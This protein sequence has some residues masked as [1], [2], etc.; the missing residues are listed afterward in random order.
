MLRAESPPAAVP[1]FRL[2][3]GRFGVL[4][5]VLLALGKAVAAD[6]SAE[7]Q[8]WLELT[9]RFRADPQAELEKLVNFSSPGVWG[10]PKSDDPSIAYAL[11]YFGT[12]A[13]DLATQFSSLVAAPPVAW[14][15]L[16]NVSATDYSNLMVTS[17][18]QSH[19]LDGYT[20]DQ[21][22]E[23][24]GYSANWLELG[25]NLF[26]STESIIHGHAGFVIDWG[27]GNGATAG[28]GNGIQNPAGHR[29]VLINPFMKEIGIGFQD[30]AIP[31]SNVSAVGPYVVTQH[32]ATEFRF[33][34]STYFSDAILTGSVYQDTIAADLFYTPGEG[35]A[36]EVI[37]VYDDATGILVAS[38]FSNSA[39]G[40]NIPLTGLTD[41]VVYRVEAPDTGL[42][43]QTF[44]LNAHTEDYG[45]PVIFYD[46]V[47]SSFMMVPEPGSLLLCLLAAV[48][49]LGFR[50]RR[51]F[52]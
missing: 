7:Q 46:N 45:A 37:N 14:N 42:A 18:Q 33:D 36:G 41:G 17:D 31:G 12:S 6:P 16:L 10:T 13:S 22:I 11:N 40:F 50:S 25:E 35:L 23:N 15:S 26:A 24:G 51:S 34:G 19:T 30:I 20:L 5:A 29:D 44:T 27:D 52:F 1:V 4:C 28:Y 2:K 43:A 47:Y 8:Y 49:L 38:G 48:P 3:R 39:G 21:R 9:N 32:F